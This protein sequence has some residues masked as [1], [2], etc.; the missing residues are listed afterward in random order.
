[1]TLSQYITIITKASFKYIHVNKMFNLYVSMESFQLGW[2][3][4]NLKL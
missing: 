2:K 3:H 4:P 1:V